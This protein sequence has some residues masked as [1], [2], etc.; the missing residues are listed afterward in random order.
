MSGVGVGARTSFTLSQGGDAALSLYR[1][2]AKRTND[3][4]IQIEFAKYLLDTPASPASASPS[5]TLNS[6][7]RTL[8][9]E[10]IFW[11]NRLARSGQPEA[12]AIKAHWHQKGMYNMVKSEDKAIA[13]Y[14]TASKHGHPRAA[15]R[16]G[17]IFERK[18]STQKAMQYYTR[19]SSQNDALA[20]LRLGKAHLWGELKLTRDYNAAL[21]YLRRASEAAVESD[22][23]S[24]EAPFLLAQL[25]GDLHPMIRLPGDLLAHDPAGAFTQFERAAE[26]GHPQA[27]FE[28]AYAYEY[29]CLG[30]EFPEPDLSINW[31]RR[32]ADK[33]NAEAMIGLSG[34][35]L[36]GLEGVLLPD[37]SLAFE[38]CRR[39]A[40]EQHLPK[41]EYALGY[42]Y[43]VGAGIDADPATAQKWYELAAQHGSRD[44]KFRLQKSTSQVRKSDYGSV[45]LKKHK[46]GRDCIVM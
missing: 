45:K 37:D 44:A 23:E 13:L 42:Y 36:T 43:E 7:Q 14:G 46:K 2:T 26:L 30:L 32:A 33:G 19:A 8:L 21:R 39:A 24:H 20:N 41:A 17:E 1:E 9:E 22:I 3:P 11:I 4:N 29:A 10:A 34:W 25:I 16:L 6:S 5:P 27:M 40:E 35:Y 12:C 18:R 28:L 15:Y 38:W 31:Y